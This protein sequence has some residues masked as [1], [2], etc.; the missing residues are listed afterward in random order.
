MITDFEIDASFGRF[1]FLKLEVMVKSSWQAI[2]ADTSKQDWYL[3]K[4]TAYG[5]MPCV[6]HA[7]LRETA[8]TWTLVFEM[9]FPPDDEERNRLLNRGTPC[10]YDKLLTW[11]DKR[12]INLPIEIRGWTEFLNA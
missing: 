12:S 7:T 8:S 10:E 2:G 5:R 6:H 11:F 4:K 3:F 1:G 9:P